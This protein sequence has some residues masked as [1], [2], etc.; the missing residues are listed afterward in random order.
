MPTLH[1][2]CCLKSLRLCRAAFAKKK[3]K[4]AERKCVGRAKNRAGKSES[5]N[6]PW[7]VTD[8]DVAGVSKITLF[9]FFHFHC[10]RG[11][12]H[13]IGY[14]EHKLHAH[15]IFSVDRGCSGKYIRARE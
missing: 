8:I 11:K 14:K 15:T 13:S 9:P 1:P 2:L 3:S 7:K 6:G 12:L 10:F 5:E 4:S